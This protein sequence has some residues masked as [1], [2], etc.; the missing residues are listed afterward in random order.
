MSLLASAAPPSQA[1]SGPPGVGQT[2]QDTK[3]KLAGLKHIAICPRCHKC[4]W[5][6]ASCWSD[7][8]IPQTRAVMG[9]GFVNQEDLVNLERFRR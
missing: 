1:S 5:I 6:S 2:L 4:F 8:P 3:M 9:A 7:G